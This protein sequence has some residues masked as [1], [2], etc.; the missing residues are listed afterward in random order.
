MA[1]AENVNF[2]LNCPEETSV[3]PSHPLEKN[4]FEFGMSNNLFELLYP[5]DYDIDTNT[6]MKQLGQF[7]VLDGVDLKEKL[8][9]FGLGDLRAKFKVASDPR[10]LNQLNYDKLPR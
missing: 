7:K 2:Y 10:V 6:I 8:A 4:F 5:K 9:K 3:A 1:E